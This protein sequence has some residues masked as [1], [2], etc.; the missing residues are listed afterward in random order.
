LRDA[1]SISQS[2]V[3][4][5]GSINA[6]LH[7]PAIAHETGIRF[8]IDDVDAV[9][10]RTPLL[11]DL[12]PGGH[13]TAKDVHDIGGNAAIL[14]ALLDGGHL[15]G[16]CLTVTGATIAETYGA[17]A[18]PDGAVVRPATAPLAPDGGLAVLKGNLCPDGA[19]IKVAGLKVL[20]HE[21]PVRVFE[22]EEDCVR[23]VEAR[24]YQPGEVLI[25]RNEG[26]VGGPGMREMLGVTAIIYGQ[27]MGEKVALV[28]D[29]RFSGAT[30]GICVGHVSPEAAIG[31][32][33]ALV[34]DGDRV[35]ID[36]AN[37][38]M[39][40]IAG[41][42]ELIARRAAWRPPV[43]RHKSGLL[44]KYAKLVGQANLGAVTHEGGAEWPWFDH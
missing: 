9:S 25:L 28:T 30:R 5:G 2:I 6:A 39:E 17:A 14:R 32:P 10:R 21:G 44:A 40:L 38:R 20:V 15:D 19:L 4:T 3:T 41:E 29:G 1:S 23:A 42:A 18:G 31:G 13:F 8:D 27:Q 35:R 34:R 33:L 22:R 43:L 11:A 24:A 37:R 12:R 26:P 7:I 16:S 36:I